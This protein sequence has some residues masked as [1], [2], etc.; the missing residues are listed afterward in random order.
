[1]VFANR[2]RLAV[3]SLRERVLATAKRP[4]GE[5]QNSSIPTLAGSI[6]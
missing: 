2:L 4:L 1:M 5:R 6:R 3:V